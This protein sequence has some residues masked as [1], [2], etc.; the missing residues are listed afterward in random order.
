MTIK[1]LFLASLVLAVSLFAN[2]QQEVSDN[3]LVI[4][5]TELNLLYLGYAN[6][7]QISVLGYASADLVIKSEDATFTREGDIW[8]CKVT[9]TAKEISA[10]VYADNG[11]KFIGSKTFNVRVLPAPVAY[12]KLA[13]GTLWNAEMGAIDKSQFEGASVVVEYGTNE[14]LE[15]SITIVCF[16]LSVPVGKGR[17]KYRHIRSDD[18]KFS[19]SQIDFINKLKPGTQISLTNIQYT[20]A[21]SGKN[22]PFEPLILK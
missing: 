2:A 9:T 20:G 7:L 14:C 22:M 6:K 4:A 1:K 11:T 17:Y 10:S 16:E 15:A 8:I 5:N 19:K 3:G 18:N 12:I 13:D 21:K